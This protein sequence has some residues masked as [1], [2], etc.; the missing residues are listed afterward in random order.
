MLTPWVQVSYEDAQWATL[1]HAG[2]DYIPAYTLVDFR[3]AYQ[4]PQ[5]WRL[6]AFLTNAF[7][8]TYI[9]GV[10]GGTLGA[11]PAVVVGPPQQYGVRIM[12]SF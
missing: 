6:E 7:N 10:T 11:A 5:H 9:A 4:S 1:F 8:K 2:Q 3:I 12:Y